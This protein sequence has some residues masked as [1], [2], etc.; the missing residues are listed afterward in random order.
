MPYNLV[1]DN[2]HRSKLRC[3]LSSSEVYFLMENG[4]FAFLNPLRDLKTTYAVH[5]WK[6]RSRLP[7]SDS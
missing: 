1:A 2:I 6:A 5:H 3:R 4:R 7:I